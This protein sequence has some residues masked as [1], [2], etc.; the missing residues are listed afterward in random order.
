MLIKIHTAKNFK[1]LK[2][3]GSVL[4]TKISTHRKYCRRTVVIDCWKFAIPL[5][6]KYLIDIYYTHTI[7]N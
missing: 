5:L 4:S 1:G 2:V 6:Y 7:S 3:R